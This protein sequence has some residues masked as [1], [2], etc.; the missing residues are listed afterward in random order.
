M[1]KV[2]PTVNPHI[3]EEGLK[4]VNN[5]TCYPAIVVVGQIINALKSEKRD[6]N[7]TS[8]V[9][10]QTGGTC[11]A[12][13]YIALIRKA[14]KDAGYEKIPVISLSVQGIENNPGFKI[15]IPII[16][17]GLMALVYGDMLLK[18]TNRVRPY[19]KIKN[20][21]N[22]LCLKWLDICKESIASG[23]FKE[24]KNI[25]NEMVNEF[26]SLE[27]KNAIKPKVAVVGEIFLKY[28]SL[29]NNNIIEIL[30]EEGAEVIIPDLIDFLLYCA[31][32]QKFKYEK[33]GG[34][35]KNFLGGRLAIRYIE[36]YVAQ[37]KNALSNSKKFML[38][39]RIE[40][41]AKGT[42]DILSLGNQ[43]GE[44]WLLTA[45]II[46]LLKSGI[47]NMICIQPFAC[48]PNHV[49][50]KG[51]IR[52]IKRRYPYLNITPIDYDPGAS[53]VNQLNRIK[54]MLSTAIKNMEKVEK[55]KIGIKN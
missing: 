31:Y 13:N 1:I 8:V 19:E 53:E 42:D 15:T 35:L 47:S 38:P 34:N 24:F 29:A 25:T 43:A 49:I 9:I 17:K 48:L 11:R 55:G 54:L 2:L 46:K 3:I 22:L 6:L 28:N 40:I 16:N 51:M 52:E 36:F 39:Q 4:Y 27:M 30:E 14:L 18:M 41:L 32:N 23:S 7:S 10:S 12:S 33:L 20:S 37:M 21:T 45:E 5:D 44:G 50:G 26:D